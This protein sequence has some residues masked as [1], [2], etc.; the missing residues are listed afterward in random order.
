M[1]E[2]RGMLVSSFGVCSHAML[3]QAKK[4]R[5]KLLAGFIIQWPRPNTREVACHGTLQY[6]RPGQTLW[7]AEDIL[8][9]LARIR[10]PVC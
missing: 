8:T 7:I 9:R 4:A 6:N 10:R 1:N 3:T 2:R 5:P